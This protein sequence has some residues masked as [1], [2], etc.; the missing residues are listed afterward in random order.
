MK[1]RQFEFR[2]FSKVKSKKKKKQKYSSSNHLN[3]TKVEKNFLCDESYSDYCG[4][5]SCLSSNSSLNDSFH[6]QTWSQRGHFAY[7]G[8]TLFSELTIKT[9]CHSCPCELC[10]P[11]ECISSALCTHSECVQKPVILLSDADSLDVGTP[12]TIPKTRSRIKTNPWLPS[13]KATTNESS[14]ETIVFTDTS[15]SISSTGSFIGQF[16]GR[17]CYSEGLQLPLDFYKDPV[18]KE[19]SQEGNEVFMDKCIVGDSRNNSSGNCII[20]ECIKLSNLNTQKKTS[21]KEFL[22]FDTD[23]PSSGSSSPVCEKFDLADNL[24]YTINFQY[25]DDVNDLLDNYVLPRDETFLSI[26]D[27]MEEEDCD[28]TSESWDQKEDICDKIKESRSQTFDGSRKFSEIKSSST[29]DEEELTSEDMAFYNETYMQESIDTGYASLTMDSECYSEDDFESFQDELE[30][31]DEEHCMGNVQCS[32][33]DWD[34]STDFHI[35][36]DITLCRNVDDLEVRPSAEENL[37]LRP[38]SRSLADIELSLDEK[39]K[40]LREEKLFVQQKIREAQEEDFIRRKQ[41]VLFQKHGDSE[42]R[43]ILLQT[44]RHLRDRLDNQ[45]RRLQSSYDTVLAIQKRFSKRHLTL[46]IVET[47]L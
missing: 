15:P 26:K 18:T 36:R 45:T 27:L 39:V 47:C 9:Y 14:T 20:Q 4:S 16:Y 5:R 37:K 30:W 46:P 12:N 43:E 22:L 34:Y 25:E 41:L 2:L 29:L 17:R 11:C 7:S 23:T 19:L 40:Q 21:L 24:Q 28:R 32:S 8:Q 3:D 1:F 6:L 10:Q 38:R 13:P 33:L 35:E 31:D 44:L 42:K